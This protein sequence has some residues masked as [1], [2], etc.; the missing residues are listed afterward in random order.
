MS[1]KCKYSLKFLPLVKA[2]ANSSTNEEFKDFLNNY[3]Y[4]PNK[5]YEDFKRGS[6]PVVPIVEPE[7]EKVIVPNK[8][9]IDVVSSSS[10][11]TLYLGNTS[12]NAML[13][14]FKNEIV[15]RSIFNKN[16]NNGKGEFI[17]ANYLSEGISN[18]NKNIYDFKTNLINSILKEAGIELITPDYNVDDETFTQQINTAVDAY[19]NKLTKESQEKLKDNFVM[20]NSFDVLLAK[21]TPFV[22][23]KPEY[24]SSDLH[25]VNKYIYSGPNVQHFTGWTNT[26][27]AD[28]TEQSSDIARIMLDYFPEIDAEGNEI[29]GSSIGLSGFT[30]VMSSLHDEILYGYS[31]RLKELRSE[32]FKQSTFD[33]GNAISVY[34]DEMNRSKEDRASILNKR[35]DYMISK[36]MS[37]KH[38]IYDSNLNEDAK[39]MFTA[40]FYKNIPVSYVSYQKN[41]IGSVLGKNLTANLVS[42]QKYKLEDVLRSTIYL[43]QNNKEAWEGFKKYF[44]VSFKDN[45][46][47]ISMQN[48]ITGEQ[49]KYSIGVNFVNNKYLFT[50]KGTM[51][52]DLEQE[53]IENLFSLIVPDDFLKISN[54]IL[55]AEEGHDLMES[56]KDLVGLAIYGIETKNIT[57]DKNDL[58]DLRSYDEPIERVAKVMSIVYGS[59]SMNVIR[60]SSGNNL[61]VYQL[62]SLAYNFKNMVN[63]FKTMQ[64]AD[65]DYRNNIYEKNLLY[66]NEDLIV[67]PPVIR[68][69]VY[70]NNVT[71]ESGKLTFSE[72]MNLAILKDFYSSY[73]NNGIIYL[74]NTTFSDKKT[75]FLI[76]YGTSVSFNVNTDD[77]TTISTQL[78]DLIEDCF[79]NG[80]DHIEDIIRQLRKDKINAVVYNILLDYSKVFNIE[81]NSIKEI[82]DYLEKNKITEKELMESFNRKH[83]DLFEDVHYSNTKKGIVFN[84]TIENYYNTFNSK[85]LMHKRIDLAKRHFIKNLIEEKFSINMYEDRTV[86]EICKNATFSGW[87]EKNSGNVELVR[88]KDNK[89]NSIKINDTNINELLNLDNKIELNPLLN[90][91]FMID[92]LLSNEYNSL[93]IG[94]VWAHPNKNKKG[95]IED[96]TYYEYSEASRLIDQ[97]KRTVIIGSTHHPFLQNMKN[98]VAKNMNIAVMQDVEIETSSI[99][100]N[101]EEKLESMNGSGLSS[102]IESRLENNSLLDAKVGDDKKT[103]MGDVDPLYGRQTLLKWAVYSITNNRRRLSFGS[104][105]SQ[106]N[107]FKKMHSIPFNINLN[108]KEFYDTWSNTHDDKNIYY[109]D[110]ETGK[111][112]AITSVEKNENG[113]W[114]F[115]LFNCD[116]YGNYDGNPEDAIIK[117]YDSPKTL[118]D[119]D[120]MFG[121]SWAMV[122]NDDTK[123]LEYSEANVDIL[124]S[125]VTEFPQL[126]NNFIAYAVN[127]SAIKVGAGNVNTND[128]KNLTGSFF[129]DTPLKTIK[130]ST[131]YGGVQMDADHDINNSEITEMTQMISALSQNGY[132]ID[133]INEIYS[134]IGENVVKSLEKY[135]VA[136]EE[137]DRSQIYRLLGES[138]MEA[139]LKQDRDVLGLA[140][141]FI[142]KANENLQKNNIDFKIPFSAPTIKGAFISTVTSLLNKK[143]IR[144]KYNGFAGVLK[145][146]H[147]SIEIYKIDGICNTYEDLANKI[148]KYKESNPAFYQVP[149]VDFTKKFVINGQINPFVK[150]ISKNDIEIEDTVLLHMKDG[151]SQEVYVNNLEKYYFVKSNPDIISIVKLESAPRNLVGSNTTFYVDG[152]KYS[153]ADLDCVRDAYETRKNGLSENIKEKYNVKNEEELFSVTS[154]TLQSILKSLSNGTSFMMNGNLVTAN[155][156]KVSPAEIIVGKSFA[157]QFMLEKGDNIAE[158]EK[159]G[160][161]FFEEKLKNKFNWPYDL[162]ENT[163]DAILYG[164]KTNDQFL[165]KYIP[166]DK[167]LSNYYPED[168]LSLDLDIKIIDDDV[169]YNNEKLCNS[170]NKQFYCYKDSF[171]RKHHLIVL[172]ELDRLKELRKSNFFYNYRL[173]FTEENLK[174]LIDFKYKNALENGNTLKLNLGKFQGTYLNNIKDIDNLSDITLEYAKAD[175]ENSLNY[176][177]HKISQNMYDSFEKSLY[178]I[179]TRIPSQGMQSFAPMKV[180]IFTESENNDFYLP[181]QIIW[182]EGSDYDIDKQYLMSFD[183][184]QNGSY[185]SGSNLQWN[186]NIRDVENLPKPN[187]VTYSEAKAGEP[188]INISLN[189]LQQVTGMLDGT[190]MPSS[191]NPFVKILNTKGVNKIIFEPL[192]QN[193]NDPYSDS[194]VSTFIAAKR[195]FIK[196]LNQH[197]QTK[198]NDFAKESALKN[199]T[200]TRI[201]DV[202]LDPK[203][204]INLQMPIDLAPVQSIAQDSVIGQEAKHVSSDNPAS[205]YYM[206]VQNMVGREVIGIV[207]VSLKVFFAASTYYNNMLS[208]IKS[209]ISNPNQSPESSS[210][211]LDLL[212]SMIVKNPINNK[213]TTIANINLDSVLDILPENFKIQV[214]NNDKNYYNLSKWISNGY[215]DIKSCLNKLKENSNSIDATL[216]LSA[217][218]SAATDNAKELILSKINATSNF[219]DIYTYLTSI[220]TPLKDISDIML[221]P[222]FLQISKL[223]DTN[224]FDSS[225]YKYNVTHAINFYLGKSLLPEVD[226]SSVKALLKVYG[227]SELKAKKYK[228]IYDLLW[229]D[230]VVKKM[231]N[232]CYTNSRNKNVE[233]DEDYI[234]SLYEFQEEQAYDDDENKVKTLTDIS[235]QEANLLSKFFERVLDRNVFIRYMAENSPTYD[236]Q[237]RD[238]E[239]LSNTILPA[240]DEMNKLGRMLGINQG[241]ETDDYDKYSYVKGIENFINRKYDDYM[242][243]HKNKNLTPFNLNLFLSNENE[244]QTQIANYD[245]VKQTYNILDIITKV[246]HFA[247]MFKILY[248]DNYLLRNSSATY[249]LERD[250][251]DRVVWYKNSKLNEKEFKEVNS[252]INDIIIFNWI[253]QSGL[254][255]NVPEGQI[256]YTNDFGNS[257]PKSTVSQEITLDSGYSIATF[258]H[259]MDN[260]I[261]PLLKTK[262]EFSNNMFIK[263][264]NRAIIPDNINK[265]NRTLWRLPFDISTSEN[266]KKTQMLYQDI[267]EDFNNIS[268]K[269]IPEIK[270]W[271]IGDLFYLYNLIVNKDSFGKNSFTKLFE[272]LVQSNNTSYLINDFY[273]W[274]SILDNSKE[275]REKLLQYDLEDLKYRISKKVPGTKITSSVVNVFTNTSDFTFDLSNSITKAVR[276]I[277]P[278]LKPYEPRFTDSRIKLNDAATLQTLANNLFSKYNGGFSIVFDKDLTNQGAQTRN[279]MAFIDNGKVYINGDKADIS[280]ELHEFTHLIFAAMKFSDDPKVRDS[281]YTL[282]STIIDHPRYKDIAKNY[283]NKYGS[284]LQEEVLVN[285][286]TT[287][288]SNILEKWDGMKTLKDNEWAVIKSIENLLNVKLPHNVD[289]QN[290]MASTIENIC[291][292]FD[293]DLFN[294]NFGSMI[295]S[296]YVVLN[297]KVATIKSRYIE[298]GKIE[299]NCD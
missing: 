20:L 179:G 185:Q 265:V 133:L 5:I 116:K 1:A 288:F 31:T 112:Y 129:D 269:I 28:S 127:K 275:A 78:K 192:S 70:L 158:I 56:F 140:Q 145:P 153:T 224:I 119:I 273:H 271:K 257:S 4:N 141:S 266:S 250:F 253:T 171:G 118:Y 57:Y 262:N 121:G 99:T 14:T 114:A 138:L 110:Q 280:H 164:S 76:P 222:I 283:K 291:D 237:M 68:S 157:K 36:L 64:L 117:N 126:K 188:G 234:Q 27:Y 54:Q 66:S 47:E 193:I 282:L 298:D 131:K 181:T 144:R 180:S 217:L 96:G 169:Y 65:D 69:E 115:K 34:V 122:Y 128:G 100:G 108:M 137:Q 105:I 267:L 240:I 258:K 73:K 32:F 88:V 39:N 87:A 53:F 52:Y 272:N 84:E 94:D 92:S 2:K 255:I 284:D 55:Y 151:S 216:N 162:P 264:L 211:V 173:N 77:N 124:E 242:K 67:G 187:G 293:S 203:N 113:G 85:D 161:T 136:I 261:I 102:P 155:N 147:N 170:E 202:L 201:L 148:V 33:I 232:W 223:S 195:Q 18:L 38:F 278:N 13:R 268:D 229:N 83:V 270:G 41:N 74:Q 167:S 189:E 166:S 228:S 8:M 177:I 295:D 150:Q 12:Y 109:F 297:Q 190:A 154:K 248:T 287:Y 246:P 209:L 58:V 7:V 134:D 191:L 184:T 243:I 143:G 142:T 254:K 81:F 6:E 43:F 174:N 212:N 63:D 26:E 50:G 196:W 93:I 104:K 256:I 231:L 206:Q 219:V 215:F 62:T 90:G 22:E 220:G 163:Y 197:S 79:N 289:L 3:F 294:F 299:Q 292:E 42:N 156:V 245:L 208:E 24:K 165:V 296:K 260:Y 91:Y 60:N 168:S 80:S 132:N 235:W 17:N 71:K 247:E 29:P 61:P 236:K 244:R 75:H 135:N 37:I 214:V 249:D 227:E 123:I 106:E 130:V 51:G 199:K 251:A 290:L 263:S 277:N 139:F 9:E 279:A 44:G 186:F 225:T 252:F 210:K 103:I 149:N 107:L 98:G 89:G 205:K 160:Y 194:T 86:R 230:D 172:S 200:A 111:Y 30:S 233:Y 207:A 204:Q 221:S 218:L 48:D 120:Q 21:N 182:I 178:F 45:V 274:V 276:I 281:Y 241:I 15:S 46:I 59:D 40:M 239:N 286:M 25:S 198:L 152:I 285:I 23:I 97:N 125:V 49:E 146:S 72:V 213:E 101:Y 10:P 259:L 11:V 82:K 226:S 19:Q 95:N 238:I 176:R 183:I 16:G 175:E 35:R 159:T